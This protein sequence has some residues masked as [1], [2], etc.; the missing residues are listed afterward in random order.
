MKI[1]NL[2]LVISLFLILIVALGSVS[3]DGSSDEK[4][5]E[6]SDGAGGSNGLGIS[7]DS[8]NSDDSDSD[9]F[10]DEDDEDSD[11]DDFDD[12]DSDSDDFDDEDDDS[13]SEN[14]NE[15]FGDATLTTLGFSAVSDVSK[16]VS[17]SSNGFDLSS[18]VTG[19]PILILALSLFALFIV[20][21]NKR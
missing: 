20:P 19:Y 12:E 16:G 2:T 6:G 9:D 11:S 3:A 18:Q 14:E 7:G 10:D 15:T 21:F 13:E 4:L 17:S 1:R 5:T 8:T